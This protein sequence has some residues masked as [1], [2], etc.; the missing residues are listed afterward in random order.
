MFIALTLLI[1]LS[2]SVHDSLPYIGDGLTNF[3]VYMPF[4]FLGDFFS[5]KEGIFEH[6]KKSSHFPRYLWYF[7][8]YFTIVFY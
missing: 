5:S 4:N 6:T 7:P 3:L 1:F 8:V 2:F